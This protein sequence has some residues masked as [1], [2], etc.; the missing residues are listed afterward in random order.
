MSISIQMHSVK[1]GDNEN[2]LLFTGYIPSKD[3]NTLYE[4]DF[5]GAGLNLDFYLPEAT[6]SELVKKMCK[7]YGYAPY[8]LDKVNEIFE[9]RKRYSVEWKE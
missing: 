9:N 1:Y 2:H 4:F 3:I 8:N 7:D 6:K 5:Y